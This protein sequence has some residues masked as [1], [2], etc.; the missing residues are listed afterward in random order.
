MV[1]ATNMFATHFLMSLMEVS[2]VTASSTDLF[3]GAYGPVWYVN[4]L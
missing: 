4:S 3:E 1:Q 2:P